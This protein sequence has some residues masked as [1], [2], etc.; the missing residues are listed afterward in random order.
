[1]I[2]NFTNLGAGT[3]L[4]INVTTGSNGSYVFTWKN[5]KQTNFQSTTI[6]VNNRVIYNGTDEIFNWVPDINS[7]AVNVTFYTN[8]TTGQQ[9]IPEAHSVINLP[10][11]TNNSGDYLRLNYGYSCA[12]NK[13]YIA[14]GDVYLNP[15]D[16]ING[17]VDVF[18][19]NQVTNKYENKFLIRKLIN[20]KDYNL[21]LAT[22]DGTTDYT[23]ADASDEF[24]ST[25]PSSSYLIKGNVLLGS[26]NYNEISTETGSGI[27]VRDTLVPF[28]DNPLDLLVESVFGLILSYNDKFG[29]SLALYGDLLA[30]GCP[31]FNITFTNG[32]NFTGGSVDIFDLTAYQQGALYYPI[33]S[34]SSA[35][36]STF[37]ESVTMYGDY[38]AIGSS[39]AFDTVGAV[40]IYKKI[41]GDNTNWQ[42]IQTLY[43]T[44][45]NCFFGGIV[46][47]DQ[48]GTYTLVVGNS[49]INGGYVYIYQMTNGLWNLTQ[50][51]SSD[52]TIPQTL[53]Y[54]NNIS[55]IITQNSSDGF[56]NSVSIYGSTIIVGAPTD[57][58]YQEYVGS[59]FKYRGSVYFFQTCSANTNQWNLL[60]K[61]WGDGETLS[62][63]Q[64]GFNVDIYG[65][66]AIA[67]AIK[68]GNN[69]TADYISNT[70][71]KRFDCNPNDP[72]FDIMGQVILFNLNTGSNMW[73]IEHT[74]QKKKLF[75]FPYLYYGYSTALYDDTFVVGSPC[76]ITDYK[77][78]P[79]AFDENIQGYAYIYNK[80]DLIS[81]KY[82]G[83]VF[84]RDGQI[85]LSN[86]GSIF[87]NLM[88]DKFDDRLS[89][90]DLQYKG[91][92]TLYEKQIVCTINPG[93]FNYS[94]NPTSMINNNFFGFPQLD[95]MLKY[96]N[97]KIYK[98]DTSWW[99]YID[100][101]D[102]EQSIF[103]FN[104]SS[105]NVYNQNITPYIQQLSSSYMKWDVDGNDKINLN[106]MTL[107]WKYFT[108]T[109]T[110][111]DI[112]TYIEPKSQRKTISDITAYIKN[113]VAIN[114]YGQI[115]PLFF[116][117]DYSSSIDK[118]GSYLAPYITTVGLYNGTDLVGV[119]KLAHPIK[120]SG[121]FP[122]NILIK[123]DI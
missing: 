72:Y 110:Q 82:V 115:N 123:W 11:I 93:E 105:Y 81:N 73:D 52:H 35:G 47:F 97:S 102:V 78:L 21:L 54:L 98:G 74:Q 48:S 6:K 1:M 7:S 16:S 5:F 70:L 32:D 56:G 103:N 60:Q 61:T 28:N 18:E 45:L 43:G 26:E 44:G 87:E 75:G 49:S 58:L 57:T 34:I 53:A 36:D 38:L 55:P 64:L 118:T 30:V 31:Y 29:T 120:N 3:P 65:T 92:V 116:N 80:N 15:Y 85:I 104:T 39:G 10:P 41:N 121:E 68:Y 9:S 86:S 40:Y 62:N 13:K 2:F 79:L 46:K 90:Y 12:N 100:F 23:G 112:F 111:N 95:M 42:L 119:A 24:I 51:L 122:L 59:P 117:Y 27:Y 50:T 83:N 4:F 108:Q 101:T 71:S 84:Y 25:E 88:K 113:N 69:F 114:T 94:T 67:T 19:Y 76:F 109:L 22:E 96:M 17:V 63:N 8:L 99:N 107:M 33:A 106:D 37:G 77:N 20:P 89:R 14:V 91:R 66:S